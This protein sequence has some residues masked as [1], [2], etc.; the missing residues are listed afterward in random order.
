LTDSA[1][2]GEAQ[3]T[4]IAKLGA[5]PIDY[6]AEPVEQYAA[7]HT[8]G[9]GFD[10]VFDTVGGQNVPPSLAAVKLNGQVA[11][12]VSIGEIDLTM[13]HLRGA[14][15]HVVY[16]LIPLI[17]GHGAARHGEILDALSAH[18]DAGRVQPIIDRVFPLAEVAEAHR[19]MAGKGRLGKVVVQVSA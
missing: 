18:V 1:G 19:R 6:V 4:T 13:A 9:R 12:T 16:M 2:H 11:T 10:A 3:L 8:D 15:L 5:T 17:H 14:T 7:R